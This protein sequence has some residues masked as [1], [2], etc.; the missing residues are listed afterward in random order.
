MHLT[1][2]SKLHLQVL[3]TNQA[4]PGSVIAVKL[5]TCKLIDI[6]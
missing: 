1:N 4:F 2:L 5:E 6:I 3:I